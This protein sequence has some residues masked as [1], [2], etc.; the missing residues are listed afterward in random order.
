LI[1]TIPTSGSLPHVWRTAI[2]IT[3]V[4]HASFLIQTEAG[5]ILTDPVYADPFEAGV[6]HSYPERAVDMGQLPKI[7]CL[8]ISHRH[9]DHFDVQTLSRLD[10]GA[11]VCHPEGEPLIE[12][13]LA[14]LGFTRTRPLKP[15]A[16]VR[17]GALEIIATPSIVSWPELGLVVHDGAST[18]W[19][20]IDTVIDKE[21]IRTLREHVPRIDCLLAQYSPLLQ[22]ELRDGLGAKT[23]DTQAYNWLLETVRLTEPQIVVPSAGGIRFDRAR[24]QNSYGFPVSPT[25]FLADLEIAVPGTASVGLEAG[26]VLERSGQS[27]QVHRQAAP[28]VATLPAFDGYQQWRH[29]PAAGMPPFADENPLQGD[30]EAAY[31]YA[32]AYITDQ[33]VRD[34]QHE[35]NREAMAVWRE[36]NVTWRLDLYAPTGCGAPETA[37]SWWLDFGQD[38]L[39]LV[40]G[41]GPEAD[42]RTAVTATGIHDLLTGLCP[43]YSFLAMDCTR[44]TARLFR[45]TPQGVQTPQNG[46]P[47][48]LLA[49]LTEPRDLDALFVTG[50]LLKWGPGHR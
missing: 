44:H 35:A 34:L 29:D 27:W 18:L 48:P 4:G 21:I 49:A 47:E 42:M 40:R 2:K 9:F 50:E 33:V 14:E 45:A 26:D 6:N 25:R 38:E 19:S 15:W 23:L 20:L 10:R 16:K 32:L 43:P 17:S 39:S 28:F 24:W 31:R 36:W 1:S 41:S 13:V 30:P 3:A 12:R 8:V 11:V 5:T 7:D 37:E 22:Y 46:L